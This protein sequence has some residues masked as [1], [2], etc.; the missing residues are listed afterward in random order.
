M[1]Q[2]IWAGEAASSEPSS[3][4]ARSWRGCTSLPGDTGC[5][6]CSPFQLQS[7]SLEFATHLWRMATHTGFPGPSPAPHERPGLCRRF[8]RSPW[9]AAAPEPGFWSWCLT[10]RT[11]APGAIP[12]DAESCVCINTPLHPPPALPCRRHTK[13][14]EIGQNVAC[15]LC[16]AP[17]QPWGRAG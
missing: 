7:F 11:A 12:C 3:A 6:P 15:W 8:A 5:S 1:L 17:A 9:G 16:P 4:G 14:R 10:R 2:S 13:C